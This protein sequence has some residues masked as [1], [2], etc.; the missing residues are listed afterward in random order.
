MTFAIHSLHVPATE[1]VDGQMTHDGV[2]RLSL[3]EPLFTADSREEAEAWRLA[4]L[5]PPNT[6]SK[7]MG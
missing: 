6:A 5:T 4:R 1:I 7:E 3:P 2:T